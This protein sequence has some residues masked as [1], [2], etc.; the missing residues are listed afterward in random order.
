MARPAA[1]LKETSPLAAAIENYGSY[2]AA[3]RRLSALTVKAYLADLG[4][5]FGVP[6]H[7]SRGLAGF[8]DDP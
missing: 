4:R 8:G 7:L 2:L 6:A 5:F 1:Q 3:E